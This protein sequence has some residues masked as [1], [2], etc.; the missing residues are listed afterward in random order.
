MNSHFN[1]ALLLASLTALFATGCGSL[2]E[3][4]LSRFSAEAIHPPAEITALQNN[5]TNLVKVAES[6]RTSAN[7]Q[8]KRDETLHDLLRLSDFKYQQFKTKL[9]V[10]DASWNSTVDLTSIG[11]SSAATLATGP[12]VPA[13]TATDTGIKAM[14]GKVNERWLNSQTMLVLIVAMDDMRAEVRKTIYDGMGKPY[15]KFPIEQGLEL[16]NRYHQSASVVNAMISLQATVAANK[17]TNEAASA[18]A[19]NAK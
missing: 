18:A 17:K 11:L 16:V 9:Y 15:A 6:V 3:Q 8:L 19:G 4:S 14:Q 7:P 5:Y 13:L 12:V 10:A 2:R 1:K